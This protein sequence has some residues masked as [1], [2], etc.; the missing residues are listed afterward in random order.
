MYYKLGQ[1]WSRFIDTCEVHP[2]TAQH[3]A[4]TMLSDV[5][6]DKVA[7]ASAQPEPFANDDSHP[8]ASKSQ[9]P[10][11]LSLDLL[12]DNS[13]TKSHPTPTPRPLRSYAVEFRIEYDA[14]DVREKIGDGGYGSVFKAVWKTGHVFCAVKMLK[15][16]D[17]ADSSSDE[18]LSDGEGSGDLVL[19]SPRD[20]FER[21]TAL[22]RELH[23]PNLVVCYG[24]C[25]GG[26]GVP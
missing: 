17:S 18:S 16:S 25:P 21:E 9:K 1:E 10:I 5:W 13:S 12:R 7:S 6:V 26:P 3:L 2:F 23:H 4:E 11:D 20:D 15:Q 14:L 8:A 24:M 22:L 19:G